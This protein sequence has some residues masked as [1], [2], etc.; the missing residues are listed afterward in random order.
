MNYK[1]V[2]RIVIFISALLMFLLFF[3]IIKSFAQVEL[4][5]TVTVDT[6]KYKYWE[7]LK[8]LLDSTDFEMKSDS[9][10]ILFIPVYKVYGNVRANVMLDGFELY[11]Y[12]YNPVNEKVD[13]IKLKN[14]KVVEYNLKSH[15]WQMK[16]YKVDSY[17]DFKEKGEAKIKN[18][19]K[20]KEKHKEK[21]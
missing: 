12:D 17:N 10:S 15:K 11:F 18:K 6:V 5:G 2:S 4:L 9:S 19:I 14:Y 7:V 8:P 1:V 20:E 3:F 21:P 13:L 16:N